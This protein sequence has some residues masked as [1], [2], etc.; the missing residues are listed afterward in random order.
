MLTGVSSR[1]RQVP[2]RI[3]DEEPVAEQFAPMYGLLTAAGLEKG[4][5]FQP[6]D[7]MKAIP[8]V[9]LL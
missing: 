4:K 9:P 6:D 8:V 5:P 2:K 3:V 7:R 1:D